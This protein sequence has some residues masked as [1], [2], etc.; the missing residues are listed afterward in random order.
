MGDTEEANWVPKKEGKNKIGRP[1]I[2]EPNSDEESEGSEFGDSKL[3][4]EKKE[5]KLNEEKKLIDMTINFD[6]LLNEINKSPKLTINQLELN[7]IQIFR[8]SCEH[9]DQTFQNIIKYSKHMHEVHVD[10]IQPF[11]DK[12]RHY[13]CFGCSKRFLTINGRTKH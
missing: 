3:E 13:V 7:E 2:H 6:V 9:C 4:E 10:N 12:Y 11:N 1:R 8:Y 5:F